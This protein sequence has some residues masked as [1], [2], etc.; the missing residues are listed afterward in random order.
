MLQDHATP[1]LLVLLT[2]LFLEGNEVRLRVSLVTETILC[3]GLVIEKY[4]MTV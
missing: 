4:L 1:P 2:E 3:A